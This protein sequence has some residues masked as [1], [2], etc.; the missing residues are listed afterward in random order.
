MRSNSLTFTILTL[1]EFAMLSHS[2]AAPAASEYQ[3]KS[4]FVYNFV[5]FVTWPETS[6]S[7]SGSDFNICL[8]G[9]D[10]F[11]M[12]LDVTTEGQKIGGRSISVQRIKKI[13]DI[14]PCQILF[15]SE[16]EED[17]LADIFAFTD[18][19]TILT[20]SDIE[21][22]IMR[23]GMIEFFSSNNKVRLGINP[24]LARKADLHVDAN[25]IQLSTI[26]E[27]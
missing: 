24:K 25:L 8:L 15:I 22:F 1:I 3:I 12:L 4:V 2:Y 16:S 20:V 23:G 18:R 14:R 11:G 21:D 5:N 6:F 26:I 7:S 19:Y 17:R 13:S 27:P 10:P 9:D